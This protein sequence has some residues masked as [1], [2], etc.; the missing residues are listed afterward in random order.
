[1]RAVQDGK[2]PLVDLVPES[3]FCL[4]CRACEPVCPAGVEYGVLLEEMRV[5][6]W[7]GKNRPRIAKAKAKFIWH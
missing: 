2:L 6:T 7:T 5:A 4:G 3:N 1:M